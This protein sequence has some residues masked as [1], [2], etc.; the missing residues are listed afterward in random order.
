V[1]DP[2]GPGR[3]IEPPDTA[4]RNRTARGWL[5]LVLPG[6]IGAVGGAGLGATTPTTSIML[7]NLESLV[8]AVLGAAA[9]LG[10]GLLFGA[11]LRSERS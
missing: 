10:L 1:Q 11:S 4:T 6:L 8:N 5:L 3:E 2:P 9:G 7:T